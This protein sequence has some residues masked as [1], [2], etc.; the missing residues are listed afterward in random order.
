MSTLAASL[1]AWI[2]TMSVQWLGG[3]SPQLTGQ[4][5]A[6][7]R[8]I[9]GELWGSYRK[10]L[11]RHKL[12]NLQRTQSMSRQEKVWGRKRGQRQRQKDWKSEERVRWAQQ[13]T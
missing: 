1:T 2:R 13:G 3:E 8:A 12:G 10:L 4:G 5:E 6:S 11:E 7:S 9:L